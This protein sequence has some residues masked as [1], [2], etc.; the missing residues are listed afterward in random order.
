MGLILASARA[1]VGRVGVAI[2]CSAALVGLASLGMIMTTESRV[3][4]LLLEPFSLLF[5]PGVAVALVWT[6]ILGYLH[7]HVRTVSDNHDFSAA[8]VVWCTFLF[9]FVALY[10]LLKRRRR[11]GLQTTTASSR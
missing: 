8:F 5:L 9:Y 11:V 3:L 10:Q 2:G 1:A 4:A 7:H 6:G